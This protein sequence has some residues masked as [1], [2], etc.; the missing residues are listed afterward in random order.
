MAEI[1]LDKD[2]MIY[3]QFE[4]NYLRKKYAD[5]LKQAKNERQMHLFF[6]DNPI[7]LPGINDRHNGPLGNVVISKLRLADEYETDFAFLS[8][9]SARTQITLIEIESPTVKVFRDSDDHF[10]S[11]FNKAV[12]QIRDWK[13][14]FR[15]NQTY[16]KDRFREI[17][18]NMIFR[19]RHVTTKIILIAGRRNHIKKNPRRERR[20]AEL[21]ESIKPDEIVTYD[22]LLYRLSCD[23]DLQRK[24]ACRPQRYIAHEL[25]RNYKKKD[26]GYLD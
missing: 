9:D 22:H 18:F 8:V 3:S 20:W 1:F 7:F 6:E 23:Y 16:I 10:T 14:W 25:K 5:F 13:A 26:Y 4:D 11:G 24:L 2:E 19:Q 12:Q 21:N 15:D 17:Y